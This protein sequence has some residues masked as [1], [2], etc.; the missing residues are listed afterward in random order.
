M[1]RNAV[2]TSIAATLTG[3]IGAGRY[4]PG[5]KLPTEA[6]L[7]RRFGVNRH[8]LRRALAALAGDGLIHTRRGAGVYV[9]AR[10][11]DY[12]IGRRVRFHQNLRAAGQTPEKKLLLTETRNADAREAEALARPPGAAVHVYEGVSLADGAPIALFRSVFPADRFPG[13]LDALTETR[14]V[15]AAL[16]RGGVPDYTRASTRLTAKLASPTQALHLALREGAPILR[17]VAINVDD[18]GRPVEYGHTWFAGDRVT[19]VVTPD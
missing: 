10:P 5:D 18:A 11:T 7:A 16:A 4:R 17:A 9:A 12:P 15:T 8:T 2:W 14:S 1:G 13:L 6:E 3:E 19:L